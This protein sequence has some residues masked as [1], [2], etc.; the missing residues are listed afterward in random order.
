MREPIEKSDASFTGNKAP[1]SS[2]DLLTTACHH[3]TRSQGT[4][5]VLG[6]ACITK[7]SA[8]ILLCMELQAS[9]DHPAGL[10]AQAGDEDAIPFLRGKQMELSTASSFCLQKSLFLKLFEVS[11]DHRNNQNQ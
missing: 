7:F 2:I 9:G 11:N 8:S 10:E 3:P 4:G 5:R 1:V 6:R